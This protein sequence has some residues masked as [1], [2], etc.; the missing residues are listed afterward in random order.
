M[1]N[2]NSVWR[3]IYFLSLFINTGS[4]VLPPPGLDE[5]RIYQCWRTYSLFTRQEEEKLFAGENKNFIRQFPFAYGF[6]YTCST[7]FRFS[8]INRLASTPTRANL[9]SRGEV[10][11][12][13]FCIPQ[14]EARLLRTGKFPWQHL[15]LAAALAPLSQPSNFLLE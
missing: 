6:E 2:V 11:E 8:V 10:R 9:K 4:P 1:W 5:P 12:K 14:R 7:I 15:P 3:H 13:Y